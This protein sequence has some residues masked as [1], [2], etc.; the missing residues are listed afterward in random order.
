MV[1]TLRM[2]E[3][4]MKPRN[5]AALWLAGGIAF[6]APRGPSPSHRT[7]RE[8]IFDERA[9]GATWE[10]PG[11]AGFVQGAAASAK[12][13]TQACQSLLPPTSPR[14][15]HS[16]GTS[17]GCPLQPSAPGATRAWCRWHAATAAHHTFPLAA[18]LSIRG[19]CEQGSSTDPPPPFCT[20]GPPRK[21]PR[22]PCL[23][24]S[25]LKEHRPPSDTSSCLSC[26]LRSTLPC[27]SSFDVDVAPIYTRL[28]RRRHAQRLESPAEAD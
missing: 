12:F 5:A 17:V 10:R 8:T 15:N 25:R 23:T 14:S 28:N 4:E 18:E 7:R 2:F 22:S 6:P 16:G 26:P 27:V 11:W 3:L 9:A 13:P 19:R 21:S 1:M 24:D 20:L